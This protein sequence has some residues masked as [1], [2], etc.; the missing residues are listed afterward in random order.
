MTLR[1]PIALLVCLVAAAPARAATSPLAQSY[2]DEQ[3]GKLA[4]ALAALDRAP[5]RGGYVTVLR[6]GWLL[7]R[8]GRH[9]E[10]VDAYANAI[11]AAPRALEPRLGILLPLLA[12]RRWVD[13]QKHARAALRLDADNYLATLRLAW[14][15]YQLGQYGEAQAL[16]RKLC[17]LYP[18]DADARSGLGWSLLKL[19]KRADA[20]AQLEKL[21]ELA[22]DHALGKEGLR[23]AAGS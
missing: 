6:R 9:V 18:A 7:Y 10:S 1:L 8:L 13:A 4:E 11:A 22:P 12:E 2:A 19:G 5:D 23:L 3:A 20:R 15:S 17:D 16:Y 14:A 21:L